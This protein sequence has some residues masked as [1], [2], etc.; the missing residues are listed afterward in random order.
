MYVLVCVKVAAALVCLCWSNPLIASRDTKKS[1]RLNQL[2][3]NPPPPLGT[4]YL[5]DGSRYILFFN[6]QHP[7][8]LLFFGYL[9]GMEKPVAGRY[10]YF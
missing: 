8:F 3:Y 9:S 4:R 1:T 2:L 5:V 6:R 7:C 10:I